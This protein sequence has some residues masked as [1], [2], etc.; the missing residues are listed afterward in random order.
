[1]AALPPDE[2]QPL[3]PARNGVRAPLPRR[4]TWLPPHA[5]RGERARHLTEYGEDTDP[6]KPLLAP[7]IV[8]RIGLW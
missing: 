1:M 3:A 8:P 6:D 4:L 2:G 7:E 5:G